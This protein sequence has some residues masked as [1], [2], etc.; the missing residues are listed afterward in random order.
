MRMSPDE[1]P[2]EQLAAESNPGAHPIQ[3]EIVSAFSQQHVGAEAIDDIYNYLT[4]SG[5][6]LPEIEETIPEEAPALEEE[7]PEEED[8]D[9]ALQRVLDADGVGVDDPVRLSL[10]EIGR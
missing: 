1:E 4:G 3:E 6:R 7:E 8:L 10:R 9:Q 5:V 2:R